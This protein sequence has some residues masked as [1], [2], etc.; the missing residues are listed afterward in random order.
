MGLIIYS[1]CQ[2]FSVP[3]RYCQCKLIHLQSEIS[4]FLEEPFCSVFLL[5]TANIMC[6]GQNTL[7]T[8]LLCVCAFLRNYNIKQMLESDDSS[9]SNKHPHICFFCGIEANHHL[10]M[11]RRKKC[12]DNNTLTSIQVQRSCFQCALCWHLNTWSPKHLIFWGKC[13]MVHGQLQST[14]EEAPWSITIVIF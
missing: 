5:G 12:P 11:F 14:L 1:S 8:H 13:I 9:W 4:A 2:R 3:A 6:L 7:P 10:V